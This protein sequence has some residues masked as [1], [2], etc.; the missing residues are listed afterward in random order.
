MNPFSWPVHPILVHFPLA[1][2]AAA[3]VCLL[4]RHATGKPQWTPRERVFEAVG[5][6]TLPL[7]LVGGF[8]DTRG[9]GR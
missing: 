5:V 6:W 7:A 4:A 2:L 3:W 1:M 9:S 8:V